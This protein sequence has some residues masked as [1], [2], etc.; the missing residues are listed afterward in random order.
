MGLFKRNNK[1]EKCSNFLELVDKVNS[2]DVNDKNQIVEIANNIDISKANFDEWV[3]SIFSDK[4]D[5]FDMN[6]LPYLIDELYKTTDKFNFML[7]CM[8]LEA[9]CDKLGFLTNLEDYQLF[10]AKFESLVNTLVTVYERVDNGIS[11]CMALIIINNDPQFEYFNDE[12]KDIILNATKEKL[13]N[14]LNY[15]KTQNIDPAIYQNLEVIVDL[16]CYLNDDEIS[17]IINEIDNLGDNGNADIFIIKYKAINNLN[18]LSEKISKL[19][20]DDE[21]LCLLYSIM[22]RLKI[23]QIYLKDVSQESIAKSDMIRWLKYPT[24]LGDSPDKIEL[25]GEFIYN[26]T[27]CFAYKFSKEGFE[28]KGDLLG[29]VGG[30]PIDKISSVASGYTF[31]KFEKVAEDWRKQAMELVE[32]ISNYWKESQKN[33]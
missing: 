3:D 2:F 11:N 18:I 17:T 20:N 30:Y 13:R 9:S 29:V 26:D 23:N 27:R 28:I 6:K 5:L 32:F 14:I 12:Q 8:L 24:E 31:S 10:V 22:E 4:I 7:C 16:A 15:L 25:L 19:K 21:K 33:S 1:K